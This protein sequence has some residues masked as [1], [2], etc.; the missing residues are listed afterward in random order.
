[1][2]SSAALDGGELRVICGPT[3]AGKST[4]ALALAERFG[5]T[6]ISADS[7]QVYRGFDVGTAKP[8]LAEQA[9]VPHR[10]IDVVEPEERYSAARWASA[11]TEWIAES[12]AAR[13]TPVIVGG[14][15]LYIRALISGLFQEP[16]LDAAQRNAL[17]TVL[18]AHPT[19]ALRRWCE[20]VDAPLAHLGRTQLIRA[21][22]IATLT[23][24]RLSDL[25]ARS[26]GAAAHAARYL[27]VDPG[28]ALA[29]R[30]EARA[31]AML[32]GEWQD[33][34][35]R[36]IEHVP[37]AAPA[38]N[39]SGYGVVKVL[40]DGQIDLATAR[41]R[42]V[43]ETRQYAKRQRTWF[44]NQLPPDATTRLSP[45]DPQFTSIAERWWE[46]ETVP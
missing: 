46:G 18:A 33:E 25:H 21:I 2:S 27:V 23:G 24:H 42:V 20:Q 10:G 14:T 22:E 30:I 36:L 16:P 26:T 39:A 12:F 29:T 35:R 38:W 40:V 9:R 37:S 19:E 11:A 7:R 6:I 4:L 13:R 28:P 3:A 5:A 31:D 1:M 43:I 34:V 8:S 17:D 44:R 41:M 32:A 45:E 15:G